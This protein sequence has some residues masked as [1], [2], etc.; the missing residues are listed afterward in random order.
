MSSS[1]KR[2]SSS[3]DCASSS[4]R[5]ASSFQRMSSSVPSIAFDMQHLLNDLTMICLSS[6]FQQS[7][8]HSVTVTKSGAR[9]RPDFVYERKWRI[10]NFPTLYNVGLVNKM[11]AGV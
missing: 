11:N 1:L 9:W 6:V 2:R 8:I 4:W 5:V 3:S 7:T 10:Q